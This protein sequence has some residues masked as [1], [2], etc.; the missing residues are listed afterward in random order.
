MVGLGPILRLYDLGK[1]KLLRKSENRS[2]PF[3]IYSV[4]TPGIP[5]LQFNSTDMLSNINATRVVVCDVQHSLLIAIYKPE[6]NCFY[7]IADD[8]IPR[9]P[10]CSPLPL[11]Y[12][13]SAVAD[14]FGG[15]SILRLPSSVSEAIDSDISGARLLDRSH[16]L[17]A[18]NK[19]II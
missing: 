1:K 7:L 11:D 8:P 4:S 13:T 5:N 18:P 16:L 15:L 10:S 17:G 9:W 3:R 14:K 19:V 2:F 12:D 6:D